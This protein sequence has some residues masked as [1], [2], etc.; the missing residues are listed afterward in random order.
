MPQARRRA[1]GDAA[2]WQ[3]DGS[4]MAFFV[5]GFVDHLLSEQRLCEAKTFEFAALGEATLKGFSEPIALFEV[6]PA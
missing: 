2:R 1:R 5:G 4:G 3:G 6:R